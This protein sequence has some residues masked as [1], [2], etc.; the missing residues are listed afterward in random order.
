MNSSDVG[1]ETAWIHA[2]VAPFASD[3]TYAFAKQEP[4]EPL[5]DISSV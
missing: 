1:L 4:A 5:V 3:N 2:L